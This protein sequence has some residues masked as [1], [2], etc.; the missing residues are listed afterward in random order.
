MIKISITEA[1]FQ[2]AS[3]TLLRGANPGEHERTTEGKVFI[4]LP[5]ASIK[6]LD[7]ARGTC[8]DYSD[9][10]LRLLKEYERIEK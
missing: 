2:A 9:T 4:W 8:E 1:A 5:K 3:K 10:I 6:V 7:S